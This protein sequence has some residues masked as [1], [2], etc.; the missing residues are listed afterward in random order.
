MRDRMRP[1]GADP[2]QAPT[3]R[4]RPPPAAMHREGV[5]DGA[6]RITHP[7]TGHCGAR[8]RCHPLGVSLR[9]ED[10]RHPVTMRHIGEHIYVIP[11]RS[12]TP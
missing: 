7:M 8:R 4:D 1:R 10:A 6:A 2:C 5:R 9:W 3:P 12:L 11:I